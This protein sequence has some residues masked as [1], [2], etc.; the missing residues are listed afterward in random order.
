MTKDNLQ[1]VV[2]II[3]IIVMFASVGYGGYLS[4][5]YSQPYR[6][7]RA[8]TKEKWWWAAKI[9][10][11]FFLP[12][13]FMAIEYPV[14]T[15][16]RDTPW[17]TSFYCIGIWLVIY[18]F[19]VLGK[20]IRF[21]FDEAFNEWTSKNIKKRRGLG[22]D[23]PNSAV[24]FPDKE[25]RRFFREGFLEGIV[26][27]KQR[28]LNVLQK[29]KPIYQ[30]ASPDNHWLLSIYGPTKRSPVFYAHFKNDL[31]SAEEYLFPFGFLEKPDQFSVFWK[32]PNN[33]CSIYIT[34]QCYALFYYG[35][36]LHSIGRYRA[37]RGKNDYFSNDA[38]NWFVNLR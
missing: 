7:H 32:L 16:N 36:E 6:L 4:Y 24:L 25:T 14:I 31:E 2:L 13:L 9:S 12:F 10:F 22:I 26:E 1:S 23:F 27:G 3:Y 34:D 38:I 8:T 19:L 17:W 35:E 18:P 21:G 37:R 20:M 33:V 29:E 5:R 30:S 15:P 28:N 11:F